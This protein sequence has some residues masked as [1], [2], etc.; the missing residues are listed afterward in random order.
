MEHAQEEAAAS[1][2]DMQDTERRDKQQLKTLSV[3]VCKVLVWADDA[4]YVHR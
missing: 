1:N 2:R 4:E 3:S